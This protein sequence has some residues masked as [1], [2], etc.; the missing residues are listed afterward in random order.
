MPGH[1]KFVCQQ[2]N[3]LGYLYDQTFIAGKLLEPDWKGYHMP[4]P[5]IMETPWAM[6]VAPGEDRFAKL[7][8]DL[9]KEWMKSG[10][11]VA[12]EK[13]WGVKPTEYSERMFKEYKGS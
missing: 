13:K 9:T 3:C 12:L 5:G 1:T 11:I 7:M 8:S 4:L 6:A 2:G 10:H